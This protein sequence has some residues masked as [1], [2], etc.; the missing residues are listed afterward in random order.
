MTRLAAAALLLLSAVS[1]EAQTAPSLR[2]TVL[3][4]GDL[5]R[6]GDLVERVAP[7]KAEIAVF[8]APD[9]GETGNVKVAV[10]MEA[11]RPHQVIGVQTNGL[12]EVSVTRA[13]RVIGGNELKT[14]IAELA[15]ER[16]RVTEGP[17][18]AVHREPAE[19]GPLMPIRANFEPRSGRFDFVF[20]SGVAQVRVTGTA[21]EAYDA[22]VL[23]RPVTRGEVLRDS[24]V[25]VVKRPKNDLQGEILRDPTAAIGM[26][27]QQTM[28][29]GHVLRSSDVAK[30][31][32]IKRSEPVMLI[33]EVPGISLT[34]RGKAED[35]G[36]LGD[37]VNVLNIQSK[38]VVQG[39]V[40]GPGQVTSTSLSPR[41]A[42]TTHNKAAG[43]RIA[44]ARAEIKAE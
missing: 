7:A 27:L 5:V 23:A 42:T 12:S 3:V 24:D 35:A 11:L 41:V 15:A 39:V 37:T 31:L 21:Q 33:Y 2:S 40:T 25:T 4:S 28:R 20:R 6:I 43:D 18:P 17:A 9:L 38:R 32:L 14:R 36:S 8:R 22:V 1:A 26:S 13:S 10:I 34:A 30:P 29:P 19:S 44:A 16:L